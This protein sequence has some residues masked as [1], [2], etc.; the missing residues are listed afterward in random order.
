MNR[1]ILM[2]DTSPG[3]GLAVVRSLGAAGFEVHVARIG[4]RSV[5]EHSRY[6]RHSLDLGDPVVDLPPDA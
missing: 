1:R 5:A 3:A 4:T 6:C 2:L